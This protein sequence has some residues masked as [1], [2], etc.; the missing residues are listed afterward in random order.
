MVPRSPYAAAKLYGHNMVNIYREAYG[1]FACAGILF[2]H[3][4]ERRGTNFV[5]RKITKAAC[6]IAAGRQKELFLGNLE[7]RRDWGY[8][9]DY[10]YA[11]WLMLQQDEP[12][13]F[14]IGTG[15]AHTVQEFVEEAFSLVKLNW[16]EYVKI[17]PKFYRPTEVVY[18][19]ADAK[20]A[21]EK[22]GW[23]PLVSFKELV[24]I[25]LEHDLKN[26]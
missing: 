6:D 23:K 9:P 21:G 18:L 15:K 13:D 1:L 16:K 22:L 25:M 3:E 7:A 26:G 19:C 4:S 10:V 5:T 17:D 20:K 12:D 14:V 24:Q 8:A 11:M 2:N